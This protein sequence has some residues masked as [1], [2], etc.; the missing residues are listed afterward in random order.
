[1]N[2]IIHSFVIIPIFQ[3]RF[4]NRVTVSGLSSERW[5]K[6][7]SKLGFFPFLIAHNCSS[8]NNS[9]DDYLPNARHPPGATASPLYTPNHVIITALS[10]VYIL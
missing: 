5:V 9:N 4:R 8:D 3:M 7:L 1:M 6:L 10:I 2:A